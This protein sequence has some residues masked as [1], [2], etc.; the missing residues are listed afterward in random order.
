MES[1]TL[2]ADKNGVTF[3][4]NSLFK[5][6]LVYDYDVAKQILL[7]TVDRLTEYELKFSNT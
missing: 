7:Q 2:S 1:K 3:Y 5:E 4:N 6:G